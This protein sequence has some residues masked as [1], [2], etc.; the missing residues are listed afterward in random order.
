VNGLNKLLIIALPMDIPM[1]APSHF[2]GGADR[3]DESDAISFTA[4]FDPR[5]RY[6]RDLH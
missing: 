1:A 2:A 5:I 6:D 4:C 3:D